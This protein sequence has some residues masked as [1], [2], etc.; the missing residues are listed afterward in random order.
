MEKP[1]EVWVLESG[2]PHLC[3]GNVVEDLGERIL[4]ATDFGASSRKVQARAL[5]IAAE[6]HAALVVLAIADET[7]PNEALQGRWLDEI[8]A[9]GRERGVDVEARV[10]SGDPVEAILSVAP[11]LGATGILVADDQ[12][13]GAMAHPCL[14]A[15]LIT[16]ASLPVLVMHSSHIGAG[17]ARLREPME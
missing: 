10:A 4:I 7:H 9:E 5:D 6:S 11:E 15:P 8:A 16:R 1:S 12:W 13:R 17:G 14:C 3:R 2:A